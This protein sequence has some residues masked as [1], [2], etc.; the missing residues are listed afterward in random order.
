[1]KK[2]CFKLLLY[3]SPLIFISGIYIVKDPF[4]VLKHYDSY[5][6][7]YDSLFFDLN[8][9]F[10]STQ[11]LIQ[12]YSKYDYDS[13]IFGSSR[14]GFYNVKDWKKYIDQKSCFHFKANYESLYG[15]ER[16]FSFLSRKKMPI[17]NALIVIDHDLLSETGN[18]KGHLRISHPALSG[19]N[20]LSFQLEF[21]K[22][23][24]DKKFLLP[25][26]DLFFTGEIKPYMLNGSFVFLK[27]KYDVET[28]ESEYY[29]IDS[30]LENDSV[31][32]YSDKP[33]FDKRVTPRQSGDKVIGAAQLKLL[34]S[35]KEILTS[36][37]SDYRI[38]I[39]PLY[40]QIKLNDSDLKTLQH[41]FG[42]KYVFDFSGV[43]S[44]TANKYNYYDLSHFK[45]RVASEIM[46]V[47]YESN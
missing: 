6:T 39:N 4:K 45:P 20:W 27:I 10:I 33:Y 15:V 26:L 19:Q 17:K 22:S 38:V 37:G 11:S 35:I 14:S 1:M 24:L 47:I 42:S 43:N 44:F 3:I 32:Y 12:N 28:N 18:G 29:A 46:H 7:E 21:V 13:Y 9:S 2:F 5:F 8:I 34:K 30:Q 40:D 41:I 25:Y 16:K 31:S 36:N 23:F